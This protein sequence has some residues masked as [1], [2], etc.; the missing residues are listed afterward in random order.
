MQMKINS[1][2]ILEKVD[3]YIDVMLLNEQE[4]VTKV[5]EPEDE[6]GCCSHAHKDID[7]DEDD[8][9]NDDHKEMQILHDEDDEKP[10]DEGLD[11]KT[12]Q[13]IKAFQKSKGL[14][15]YV[16]KIGGE[17]IKGGVPLNLLK[18]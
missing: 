1:K 8:E 12:L 9:Y 13:A 2:S 17:E 15:S 7:Y 4:P 14:A 6:E 18:K 5:T 11:A 3:Y 10:V 16:K